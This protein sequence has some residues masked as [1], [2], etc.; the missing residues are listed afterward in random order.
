M[1]WG[2]G[3]VAGLRIGVGFCMLIVL[4]F[5]GVLVFFLSVRPS[6]TQISTG[7]DFTGIF[8]VLLDFFSLSILCM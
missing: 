8:F 2:Y 1:F 7:F 5:I 3:S 6:V 4:Y